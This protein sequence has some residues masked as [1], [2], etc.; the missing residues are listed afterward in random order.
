MVGKSITYQAQHNPLS[1]PGTITK[2]S[3]I[4]PANLSFDDWEDLGERLAGARESLRWWLGDWVNFGEAA[5]GEKYAQALDETHYS[6]SALRNIAYTTKNTPES[7]RHQDL[8][9]EHHTTVA[10][11]EENGN[12]FDHLY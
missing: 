7:L 2:T 4:L 5:Y 1:L 12:Y 3:L 10:G 11:L 6:Y 8:T 9:F